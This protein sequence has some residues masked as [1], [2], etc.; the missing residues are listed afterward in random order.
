MDP[1][2]IVMT[3]VL[4]IPL[5]IILI[6]WIIDFLDFC[7]NGREISNEELLDMI[8]NKYYK[9]KIDSDSMSGNVAYFDQRHG[10]VLERLEKNFATGW[11][12]EALRNI[13]LSEAVSLPQIAFGCSEGLCEALGLFESED[14]KVREQLERRF[15]ERFDG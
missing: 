9:L 12:S 3:F 13:I 4:G 1:F 11:P 7:M 5:T 6:S 14:W 2:L 8:D 10:E 15:K